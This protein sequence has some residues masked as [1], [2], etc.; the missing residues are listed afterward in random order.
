MPML[1]L[2][3][4][5]TTFWPPDGIAD[6]LHSVGGVAAIVGD[7][8]GLES[9]LIIFSLWF[10]V[11][12]LLVFGLMTVDYGFRVRETIDRLE[13]STRDLCR[14]RKFKW[15]LA[16]FIILY[17]GMLVRCLYR[18]I[19]MSAGWGNAIVKNENNITAMV[20]IMDLM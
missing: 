19:E 11:F 14:S 7:N 9:S 18:A 6:Y 1:L 15:R 8:P 10:Q 2:G 20:L 3:Y 4:L 5:P 12:T 16:G 17:V 13:E